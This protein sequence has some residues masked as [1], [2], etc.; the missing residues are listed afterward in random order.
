MKTVG[1][2]ATSVSGILV[3]A[4]SILILAILCQLSI[5]ECFSLGQVLRVTN[6]TH[7]IQPVLNR[8]K[9]YIARTLYKETT[10]ENFTYTLNDDTDNSTNSSLSFRSSEQV[11]CL[12]LGKLVARTLEFFF[13]SQPNGTRALDVQFLLSSR[14]QPQ[15][16][17]VVL[18]RQ[19]GLEWADFKI[20]RRTVIIVHGFLSH[21][22]EIWIKNME[23]ALLDWVNENQLLSHSQLTIILHYIIRYITLHQDDVNVV[24]IDWS[25]GG[26]TWNYYKAAVNTKVVGYQ[27]SK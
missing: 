9:A 7:S 5:G 6:L 22:Q 1:I 18:G 26:N 27:I 2:Y 19:F 11:D 13:K 20:E 3:M 14:N 12:G 21:S 25:A 4:S 17:R 16:V 24:V 23:Q 8:T 10:L 15:R